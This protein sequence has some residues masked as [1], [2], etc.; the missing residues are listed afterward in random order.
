MAYFQLRQYGIQPGKR[1]E[2]IKYMDEV[3][4]PY[5]VSKGDIVVASFVGPL[6]EADAYIWLRRYESEEDEKRIAEAIKDDERT[7][8]IIAPL[9]EL[10][11]RDRVVITR[12][13][14]SPNSILR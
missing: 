10:M 7:D 9:L 12:L 2:M 14:A 8:G 5:L 11:D 13:E 3:V 4:I 1:A 6:D